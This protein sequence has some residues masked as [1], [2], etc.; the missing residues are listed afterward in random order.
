MRAVHAWARGCMC[1]L[2]M[3]HSLAGLDL[4]VWFDVS[5]VHRPRPAKA[6]HASCLHGIVAWACRNP[7]MGL[8]ENAI[9]GNPESPS[10]IGMGLH[11]MHTIYGSPEC[12]SEF[13]TL[14]GDMRS[15]MRVIGR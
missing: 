4:R 6:S 3:A 5:S 15:G 7:H 1:S 10:P 11:A 14:Q 8:W 13:G 9:H 12:G 2:H